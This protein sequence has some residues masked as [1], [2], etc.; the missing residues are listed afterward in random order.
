MVPFFYDCFTRFFIICAYSPR[1]IFSSN[2]KYFYIRLQLPHYFIQER[3]IAIDHVV[4]H[5]P[6][7][8]GLKVLSCA[9]NL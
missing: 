6:I 7:R 8:D 2:V 9:V 4:Y 1:S 5:V 3:F